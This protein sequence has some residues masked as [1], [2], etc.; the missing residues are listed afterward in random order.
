MDTTDRRNGWSGVGEKRTTPQHELPLGT[1]TTLLYGLTG[2][3]P[4]KAGLASIVVATYARCYGGGVNDLHASIA[5]INGDSACGGREVG[6]IE[7]TK[8]KSA[9]WPS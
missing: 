6:A 4:L 5:T 1:P 2:Q 7:T 8:S 9:G 3:Y